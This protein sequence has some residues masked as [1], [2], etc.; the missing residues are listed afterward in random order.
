MVPAGLARGQPV[1]DRKECVR[2]QVDIDFHESLEIG[3]LTVP[4]P[5]RI[6][7]AF[8]LGFEQLLPCGADPLLEP[9]IVG[10]RAFARIIDGTPL[11]QSALQCRIDELHAAP[12][13]LW[14]GVILQ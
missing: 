10:H 7:G 2:P 6:I 4:Q 3:D 13:V 9:K 11:G 12:D 8:G 5:V 14:I 1:P